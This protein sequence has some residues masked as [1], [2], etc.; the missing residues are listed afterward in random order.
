MK[1]DLK[2]ILK[3]LVQIPT[4]NPPGKTDEIIDYL[5]TDVFKESEGFRNEI[6]NYNKKDI[7]LKNL[8]TRIGTG[9]EKIILSGHLD[10]VPAGEGSQWEYPPFSAEEINGKMYGRGACDM[11]GG[12]TML[13]GTIIH[14]KEYPELLENYTILLLC[15]ADEESG[16]TGAINFAR[17]GLMKNSVLLIIGE[18]TNMNIGIAEKGLL[19][20]DFHVYGKTGHASTPELGINSIECTLKIIPQL[21]ECLDNVE[22]RVL[23]SSTL[24]VGKISGGVANNIVP[25]KTVLS[26]DYR[27]IPEQ[28]YAELIE[29]LRAIDASPCKIEVKIT[30]TLPA[31][32]TEVKIPFIQNLKKI[33][34]KE[35]IGIPYATDAGVLVQKKNPVPFVIYGPGDP[36]VIHKPNEYIMIEDVVKSTEYLSQALLQTFLKNKQL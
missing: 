23:G 30:Y 2:Q 28:D 32:Q 16:M 24:N 7:E 1:V 20:A 12:L 29:N 31:L 26:V 36:R 22:N 34:G 10:V 13:I 14:L 11:K 19:W 17:K 15:S 21:H 33:N 35:I 6:M 3:N 18:P 8:I 5:I 9:K 25:D 27:Y 4:E